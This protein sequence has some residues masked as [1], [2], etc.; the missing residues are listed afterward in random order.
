MNFIQKNIKTIR[1]KLGDTQQSFADRLGV[2]RPVI[3]AYEEGRAEPKLNTLKKIA[4]LVNITVD[5]L[6]DKDLGGFSDE[7]WNR[8]KVDVEG[9]QLRVLTVSVDEDDNECINLVQQKASAGY[10]NGFSDPEF[11]QELPKINLPFLKNGTFRG[12]EI[13]GDSM[14]PLVSGTI[15]VG[16][17]IDNWQ[18]IKDNRTY[19]IISAEEGT[20]YKRVINQIPERESL[21][22]K[23]DN[24]DYDPYEIKISDVLEVWES[25]IYISDDF[26]NSPQPS[27]QSPEDMMNVILKM[28]QDISNLKSKP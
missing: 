17:Y 8:S 25:K 15:I 19:V 13:K 3:G 12:F 1:K 4:K 18:E 16:Q 7:D 24:P 23:S 20:V 9:N 28:Q 5:T 26:P 2:K 11:V 21:L 22:L 27:Q 10:M 14:L 6:L